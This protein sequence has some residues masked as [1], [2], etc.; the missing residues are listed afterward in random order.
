MNSISI[1]VLL[2]IDFRKT[3]NCF[4]FINGSLS[5][6][7]NQKN[8][9]WSRLQCKFSAYL[10]IDYLV[11]LM[12][13]AFF[14]CLKHLRVILSYASAATSINVPWLSGQ[15][16]IFF[17]VCLI[18]TFLTQLLQLL[19]CDCFLVPLYSKYFGSSNLRYSVFS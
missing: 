14:S 5:K 4:C 2:I 16:L 18:S 19:L 3:I 9:Q 7:H 13:L 15:V 8:K 11:C 1:S 10:K 6:S 17:F 12:F